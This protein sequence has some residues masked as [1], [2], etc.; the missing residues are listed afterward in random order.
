[1]N[2][3][4]QD[5]A[6]IQ[7]RK[8]LILDILKENGSATV[9]EIAERIYVSEATV[10]RD[11]RELW[12]L[13][14]VERTHG[15]AVLSDNAE[16]ISIFVRMAENSRGK[17]LAATNALSLIP[18]FNTVFVDS[19]STALALAS[20]LDLSYK[21]VVTNNL[22]TAFR[23]SKKENVN[24]IILGGAVQYN[25]V[26]STGSY[27]VRS[28]EE[29]SFDLVILSCAA[30]NGEELFERS[31]EQREIKLAALKRGKFKLLVFDSSKYGAQGAYK[32]GNLSDFD[33]IATDIN[34]T[35]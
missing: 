33:R 2:R 31:L 13:G 19:S 7:D 25:T 26:S 1:M 20:R 30:V 27:T 9:K 35:E 6:M 8:R 28:I 21:T 15:G 29:F 32:L 24:V 23:L 22:E 16:E 3:N 12:R 14:M 17:E 34:I 10:R 18:K 5:F 4:G 11:L